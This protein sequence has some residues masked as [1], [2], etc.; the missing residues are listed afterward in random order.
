MVAIPTLSR[1]SSTQDAPGTESFPPLP[2]YEHINRYWD[3]VN[4]CRAAKILPGEYYVTLRGELVTTVLGSCV[5][6]CIR[7]R[8]LGLGGMNHFMLPHSEQLENWGIISSAARYGSYAME[9]L[10]N[11]IL[12]HGGRRENLEVKLFGGGQVLKHK[13]SVGQRNIAFVREYIAAEG[14]SLVSEDL[15]GEFPRKVNYFPQ[16]GLARVKKLKTLQNDTLLKRESSY[17]TTLE[18]APVKQ[19]I[20][21]F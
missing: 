8:K 19:D 15:G 7:D 9:V 3:R 5:A 21:L 10:I 13:T 12:K 14:L 2:G 1:F 20:E 16:T 4:E 17:L 11:D 6:A 18:S